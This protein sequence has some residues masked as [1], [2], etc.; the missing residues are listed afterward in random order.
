[1][2]E[3]DIYKT[4]RCGELRILN[5]YEY[6]KVE[7]EF[8]VTGTKVLTDKWRIINGKVK[9]KFYPNIW[10]V[11]FIGE[12][13]SWGTQTKAYTCWAG[14]LR[15]CYSEHNQ[16]KSPTYIGC[17]VCKEWHNFQIFCEWYIDNYPKDGNKY[18]LDKDILIEGNREYSPDNCIFT[19]PKDNAVKANAKEYTFVSP[20]GE[21]TVLYNLREFCR[22]NNLNS[23]GMVQVNKGRIS[24]HKGWLKYEEI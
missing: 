24:N 13:Y 10:T 1:M 18:Q 12:G 14:M 5:F 15:R 17:Y 22:I 2:K 23:S 9:D 6:R 8:I 16:K 7:V 20:S 21:V 11:G 4:T 19:T 3:G